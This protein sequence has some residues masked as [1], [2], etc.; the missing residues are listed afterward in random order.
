MIEFV[1]ATDNME[2]FSRNLRRSPIIE[3]RSALT[4]KEG[5][6]NV[7]KAYNEA[8]KR[9][10]VYAHHDVFL[11]K[12]FGD[13]LLQGLEWIVDRDVNFGVIGVAGVKLINGV[14]ENFGNISDRGKRWQFNYDKLPAEVD[15]LDELL[16]I[17]RGDFVFDENLPLDFYGA[18]IC[19]QARAQGRKCYAINAYVEHNSGRP[20]SG[21][22]HRTESY[23]KSREVFREKWK[24][25]LP[26]VTTTGI[27]E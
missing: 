6:T 8:H 24:K 23:Y 17:T 19:M 3:I 18:D 20:F 11:P 7:S 5:Y 25:Y 15:T 4:I 27:I 10:Y 26:I 1:T 16:L 12:S 21:E 2:I 22:G 14:R 9:L 13:D